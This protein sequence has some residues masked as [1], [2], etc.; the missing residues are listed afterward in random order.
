MENIFDPLYRNDYL[1][2][3]SNGLDPHFALAD[4]FKSNRAYRSGFSYGRADY[5]RMN[6]SISEGIPKMIVTDSVLDDFL[7]AG[8]LGM[9]ID[10]EGYT[11]RQLAVIEKWYQSG[12]EKYDL[13]ENIYLL[14]LLEKNGIEAH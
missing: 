11:P 1:A 12:V 13:D 2:G 10:S 7:L 9:S 4:C 14:A 6:G 5:E 8:M 3:Y